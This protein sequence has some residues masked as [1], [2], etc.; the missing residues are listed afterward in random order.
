MTTTPL[1]SLTD[2]LADFLAA[3]RSQLSSLP[4]LNRLPDQ[5][6]ARYCLVGAGVVALGVA[7][8]G[9]TSYFTSGTAVGPAPVGPMGR[10]VAAIS[11]PAPQI[12]LRIDKPTDL[13]DL[14]S[15]PGSRDDIDLLDMDAAVSNDV[16]AGGPGQPQAQSAQTL[17][18]EPELTVAAIDEDALLVTGSVPTLARPMPRPD[19]HTPV[20]ATAADAAP[21]AQ[22]SQTS[23]GALDRLARRY[24]E[25]DRALNA[26][27]SSRLNTPKEVRRVLRDL[28]YTKADQIGKGW[29]AFRAVV[30]ANHPD[31]ARGVRDEIETLGERTVLKQLTGSGSYARSIA[32]AQSA[33]AEVIDAIAEDNQLMASL[34]ERF[35]SAARE[36]QNKK[37][38]MTR[39]LSDGKMTAELDAD[40][41]MAD[42]NMADQLAALGRALREVAGITPAH[43]YSPATMERILALGA[44]RVIGVSPG[45][46]QSLM[47][48]RA[49]DKC[50]KWARLNLNQ[51]LAAA[52]F[53]S[54][55]AWCTG[56]HAIGDVRACWAK[57]LPPRLATTAGGASR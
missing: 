6:I 51:C 20:R 31:F 56:K 30:A 50:L 8:Y 55:E 38:G 42:E 23:A 34:S 41:D 43:A 40:E 19:N 1:S 12:E 27:A 57:A 17:E 32:G 44:Q 15:G 28:R 46:S 25:F 11:E 2:F 16:L 33:A 47:S 21:A 9:A 7:G 18:S 10:D 39:P 22:L 36:F 5:P 45:E 3:W 54:E 53:P 13:A 49:S 48:D 35:L 37:W 24:A 14:G 52:H 26:A 29:Y 4:G